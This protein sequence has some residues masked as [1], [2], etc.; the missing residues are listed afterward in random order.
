MNESPDF[1]SAAG[2]QMAEAQALGAIFQAGGSWTMSAGK[3]PLPSSLAD[4]LR[5]HRNA[6]A[7]LL[8]EKQT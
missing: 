5:V 8:A 2:R 7:A 6:I 1:L 3:P 4:R